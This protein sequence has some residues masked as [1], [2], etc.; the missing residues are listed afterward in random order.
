MNK[1]TM[2]TVENLLRNAYKARNEAVK[3]E[4]PYDRQRLIS[5][6]SAWQFSAMELVALSDGVEVAQ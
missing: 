2:A 3:M 5:L 6:A 4:K 1:D